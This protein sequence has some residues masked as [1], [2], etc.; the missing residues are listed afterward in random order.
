MIA[1]FV[2]LPVRRK[3][4]LF[5][6]GG[7]LTLL[8]DV[9][10]AHV[11]SSLN[12]RW[13]QAVPIIYG[14]IAFIGLAVAALAPLREALFNR[15]VSVIGASGIAVGLAGV[16]LHGRSIFEGL[17]GEALTLKNVMR[18]LS[19]SAPLFAPAAFAGVGLLLITLRRIVRQP[20]P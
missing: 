18:T 15:M 19:L 1:P 16:F 14:V 10:V 3:V 7:M 20:Y 6:A 2:R 13:T 9:V 4:V 17:E 12:V 11:G 5:V 8:F